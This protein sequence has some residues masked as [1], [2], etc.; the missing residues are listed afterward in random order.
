[1]GEWIAKIDFIGIVD[2]TI[3]VLVYIPD[4]TRKRIGQF[5][6][7]GINFLLG[8]EITIALVAVIVIYCNA[9]VPDFIIVVFENQGIRFGVTCFQHLVDIVE[10]HTTDAVRKFSYLIIPVGGDFPTRIF[11]LSYINRRS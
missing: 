9:I 6:A 4:I 3:A 7:G 1:M 8:L 11:H 5:G 10:K 2:D